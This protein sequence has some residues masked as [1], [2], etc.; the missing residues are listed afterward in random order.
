[1]QLR[2]TTVNL[3]VLLLLYCHQVVEGRI[4]WAHILEPPLF[5]PLNWWDPEPPLINNGMKWVGGTWLPPLDQDVVNTRVTNASYVTDLLPT[6]LMWNQTNTFFSLPCANFSMQLHLIYVSSGMVKTLTAITLLTIL[7]TSNNSVDATTPHFPKCCFTSISNL[8]H[9]EW[10]SC[11]GQQLQ[12][13][14]LQYG[15]VI[16]WGLH[17]VLREKGT[18]ITILPFQK[19]NCSI[20]WHD[21]GMARSLIQYYL[22]S[23][24]S[25]VQKH[26]WKMLLPAF[27][28]TVY[29]VNLVKNRTIRN[30]TL[31]K[32]Q[33]LMTCTSH[34]YVFALANDLSIEY[35]NGLY[36]L[37]ANSFVFKSCVTNEKTNNFSVLPFKRKLEIWVPVNLTRTWEGQDGL[38]QLAQLFQEEIQKS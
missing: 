11:I 30:L 21:G 22:D 4:Y 26:F 25:R 23:N 38:S 34:L 19:A 20:V 28:N 7:S 5:C 14:F 15:R 12:Q 31:P 8:R 17:G 33:S 36:F 6:C 2:M 29:Q 1:M 24:Q 27:G 13:Q 37:S 18:N 32:K 9:L 35:R 10:T 3:A 16:D